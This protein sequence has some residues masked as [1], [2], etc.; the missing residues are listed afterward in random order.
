MSII[1]FD[2]CYKKKTDT[3]SFKLHPDS[4]YYQLKLMISGKYRIYDINKVFIYYKGEL[5][6]CNDKTKLREIFKLRKI[7]LEVATEKV[8][9][10][11]QQ[12]FKYYCKCKGGASYVCDKCDEF[13]CEICY[14][15]KKHI[16]HA[17][18]VIK[19]NEYSTYIKSILKEIASEL[20][21]KII[22]DEAFQF[23]NYWN[24]D[25][26]T[27]MTNISQCFDFI[28]Q[29]I[30]DIKQMQIDYLINL[31]RYDKYSGLKAE[32]ENVIKEFACVNIN[33]ECE[34]MLMEKKKII[35][36]S[37]EVLIKFS[38][39]KNNLLSYTN[40]I[41]D[42]E[43]FNMNMMKEIKD[44]FSFIKKKYY[45]SN[46]NVNNINYSS[47][48]SQGLLNNYLSRSQQ[49][50]K[51][52]LNTTNNNMPTSSIIHSF[53][54][55]NNA[56]NNPLYQSQKFQVNQS[57]MTLTNINNNST[58]LH[59]KLL[60][61]L[62]DERKII[63]FSLNNQTFKEKLFIDNSNFKAN[64]TNEADVTQLNLCNK[65]YILSGKKYN[66]LYFYDYPTNGIYYISNTLYPHYYGT[67]I[68]VPKNNSLYLMGGNNQI[69][70]EIYSFDDNPKKEWRAL[71]Q[72]NEERQEFASMY[73]KDYIYIFF[74]FSPK[75]GINLS[76]IERINVDTN[77]KFELIYI[78]EQ[79]TLS[80]LACA[81]YVDEDDNDTDNND[82]ILL[83]GGFDGKNY[84]D[85]SLV[86]NSKEMKI[87][88]CDIIIPNMNK[89]F[90]FL[91]HKES[92]FLE[93]DGNLQM[94]FDMKNNVH[95]ISK[96]SYELFSQA[97]S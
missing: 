32:I 36:D 37:N 71:P 26:T 69:K 6:T 70:C 23:F 88:D 46:V 1:T 17:S 82:E 3:D 95:L 63:I 47:S 78:N 7:K 21:E 49:D 75:K 72:L 54:E 61:K 28:K 50:I 81:K 51:R 48:Q 2:I 91:F 10:L 93:V 90:Q 27:E 67:M 92:M 86:F 97:P 38:E 13:L 73:F 89:H 25:L 31:G 22:N 44:K 53:A 41:K 52:S 4:E 34:K 96:E 29:E 40:T 56:S 33:D 45:L 19:I 65:L 20:D 55:N 12:I 15:K 8:S 83:L 94:A 84:V 60:F 62:K 24:Y 42:M 9:N 74:G 59:D 64:L 68:Y 18:K 43:N 14:K 16:T 76:S 58:I 79:I 87:R 11:K 30:E 80:S 35:G 5:L 77:D 39:L 66:K 85:T 57:N